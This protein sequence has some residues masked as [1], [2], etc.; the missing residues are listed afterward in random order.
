MTEYNG[1]DLQKLEKVN[2]TDLKII[3]STGNPSD[4][5]VLCNGKELRGIKSIKFELDRTLVVGKVILEILV[6]DVIVDAKAVDTVIVEQTD[7]KTESI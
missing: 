2:L 6:K 3:S 7:E 1:E 4:M 5:I